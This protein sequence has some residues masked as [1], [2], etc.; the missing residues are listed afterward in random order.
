[1]N[2]SPQPISSAVDTEA[3]LWAARLEGGTLTATDRNALDTWLAA[4]PVHRAALSSYCQF[5][6]DLEVQLPALVAAGRVAMPAP[7]PRRRWSWPLLTASALAA[8]VAVALTVYLVRPAAP[9]SITT[10][11]AQRQS[12][13]LADGTRVELNARTQLSVDLAATAR[14]VRLVSGE[15]FFQ[16][17]K[18]PSRPFTI[19]TPAGS[20]R[21]TGTTFN[22]LAESPA[23]LDVTV[24]EGSVQVQPAATA[25]GPSSSG[26]PPLAPYELTAGDHLSARANTGVSVK[27]IS[28]A[29]LANTLAWRQGAVVFD[30]VPLADALDRFARYHDRIITASPAAATLRI[31]SRFNLDDLDGFFATLAELKP[32]Q[33]SRTASGTYLVAL[34]SEK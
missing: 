30:D 10:A 27:P 13:T 11:V 32:V 23:A 29:A 26:A 34:R 33:A 25:A 8:T 22:V 1:M 12:V 18:D 31:S 15:A 9:Q 6:A 3:A 2:S 7:V 4:S 17:A 19:E 20:V 14:H 24:V 16:V 28:A 21:V 5:S